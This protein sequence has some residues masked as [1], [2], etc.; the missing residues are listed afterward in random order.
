MSLV[1]LVVVPQNPQETCRVVQLDV[2]DEEYL[3]SLQGFVGGYITGLGGIGYADDEG[4]HNPKA[5]NNYRGYEFY[6]LLGGRPIL[7]PT[8]GKS[9]FLFFAMH[10][11]R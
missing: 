1:S 2:N 5:E 9:A 7:T 10:F 3:S 6:T 11:Y 8:E 4:M